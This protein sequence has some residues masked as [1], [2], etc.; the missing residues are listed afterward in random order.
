MQNFDPYCDMVN[1]YSENDG[2]IEFYGRI[3]SVLKASDVVLDIGAGRGAWADDD[4]CEYR[5]SIRNLKPKVKLLIGADVDPIV[6]ENTSTGKNL[7]MK[8]GIVPLSDNSVD[9]IVADFVLEHIENVETFK[10]ELDRVLVPGGYFCARTPH[11]YN[12]VSLWA[13]IIPNK[14]H[15]R[16]LKMVQPNRKKED[17]FPTFFR[18]NTIGQSKKIFPEYQNYSYI[19]STSPAYYFGISFLYKGFSWLHRVAPRP[20]VGILHIFVRKSGG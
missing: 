2:T 15:S 16:V 7:L 11:K 5:K 9:L 14:L 8:N 17:V 18:L 20:F 4:P 3:K 1:G 19:Y 10:S 13:R 6:L 12:Y